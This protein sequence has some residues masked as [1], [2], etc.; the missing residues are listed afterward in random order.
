MQRSPLGLKSWGVLEYNQLPEFR[1]LEIG[2][3]VKNSA[4]STV[5]FRFLSSRPASAQT[6]PVTSVKGVPSGVGMGAMAVSSA[7]APRKREDSG[8]RQTDL[9]LQESFPDLVF[10]NWVTNACGITP[11]LCALR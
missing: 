6:Q 8:H 3:S 9:V 7:C 1:Q 11:A 5:K 2:I 10:W 4:S